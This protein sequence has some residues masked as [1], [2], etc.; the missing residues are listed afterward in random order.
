MGAIL[1]CLCF[2]CTILVNTVL[3]FINCDHVLEC[4]GNL[5]NATQQDV[6]LD[7]Y[8]AAYGGNTS[9]T[10][11]NIYC[12]G[13]FSCSHALSLKLVSTSYNYPCTGSNSCSYVSYFT[14]PNFDI[15]GSNG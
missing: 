13:S 10:G 2:F 6:N 11:D 15:S 7:A 3:S 8:K 9:I 14:A 4:A 1:P 5:I 12:H